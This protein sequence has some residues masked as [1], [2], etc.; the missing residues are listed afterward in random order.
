MN[1][2]FYAHK[3]SKNVSRVRKITVY[4]LQLQLQNHGRAG[5]RSRT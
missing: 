3:R 2:H 5:D 1:H 4:S